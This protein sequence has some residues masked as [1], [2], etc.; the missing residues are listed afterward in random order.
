MA[1]GAPA[2]H[3]IRSP[4]AID[5]LNVSEWST[6]PESSSASNVGGGGSS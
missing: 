4:G 1:R 2:T 5:L 6:R 3:A